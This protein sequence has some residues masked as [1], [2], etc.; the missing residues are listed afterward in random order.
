MWHSV[1]CNVQ[2]NLSA[3]QYVMCN[4]V[5][6]GPSITEFNVVCV[7][8]IIEVFR[9]WCGGVWRSACTRCGVGTLLYV[10]RISRWCALSKFT[11]SL[12]IVWCG[13]VRV[14]CWA[15]WVSW[16][17][18]WGRVYTVERISRW[19]ALPSSPAVGA[20]ATTLPTLVSGSS[21]SSS[22]LFLSSSF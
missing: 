14:W 15:H 9:V 4:M 19:C 7:D 16:C 17:V 13:V 20:R 5:W 1:L 2:L 18:A 10:E 11:N 3:V 6:R 21:S 8:Q 12:L 22:I